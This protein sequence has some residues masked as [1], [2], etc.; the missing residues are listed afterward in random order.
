[1][2][3]VL[4]HYA[5]LAPQ[6]IDD[7]VAMRDRNHYIVRDFA[8]DEAAKAHTGASTA[9]ALMTVLTAWRRRYV[10]RRQLRSLDRHGLADIGL[11]P[12]ARHR[13]IAKPFW[14][15]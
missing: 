3:H 4:R 7:A 5:P 14:K 10:T 1:M 6:P 11:D 13:E 9:A 8:F 15:P 2:T 12:I